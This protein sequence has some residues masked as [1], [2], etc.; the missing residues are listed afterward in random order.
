M[1]R[2][3]LLL[4]VSAAAARTLAAQ[5]PGLPP[6]PEGPS[7][8]TG[9]HHS[10]HMA[11]ALGAQRTPVREVGI[12]VFD[13]VADLDV[14]GPRSVLAGMM[15]PRMRLISV[16]PGPVRTALGVTLVPEATIADV[17][18]LDL[19]VVPG[20]AIDAMFDERVL[21]WI[22]RVDRTTTYTASVCNGAWI[23][24]ATGLLEG[25]RAS[26]HWYRAEA[27][28]A[29]YG[30]TFSG[31]RYTH[32]GKY[33]TSTGITA[34]IDMSLALLQDIYGDAYPQA[35]MLDMEYD[36]RPPVQGGTPATTPA[37]IVDFMT[38]MYDDAF[39]AAI[40][41]GDA[42][43]AARRADAPDARTSD[44]RTSDAPTSDE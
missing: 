44:A 24:A 32:D 22:R 43:Q 34:G 38:A 14:M 30:A 2:I 31:E 6:A 9:A 40:E 20:G 15:T 42:E 12:L 5:T 21:D 33:W 16:H 23:L 18:S 4:V 36:P 35:V 39:L 29:R 17:D 27:M 3:L 41:R 11:A 8:H 1:T 28:L 37:A 25:R 7:D 10:D 26:T 13:G 19:L